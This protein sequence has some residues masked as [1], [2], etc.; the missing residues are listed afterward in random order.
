MSFFSSTKD[1]PQ[2]KQKPLGLDE[3]RIATNEQARPVPY[4]CGIARLAVTF[5]SEAF[6]VK[7]KK[8]KM[9]VGKKQETVGYNYIASFAALIA[10]GPLDRLDAIWMDDE[11]V[12]EGPLARSGDFADIT[13]EDRG[14]VR[15][16][17]GTETQVQDP[18]LATSGT[19]HPAYRGQAYLVFDQ[20]FFGRDR[21]NAP[22]IE[23][24]VARWPNAP[25]LLTPNSI[26][27]DVNPVIPLWDLWTNP[28]YGLG[29]PESRLDMDA[30]AAVG[31]QL[32]AEGIGVSPVI[33]RAFNFRQFLVELCECFDAYP[34]YDS[35]GRLGLA[36]VRESAAAPVTVEPADLVDAPTL[37]PQGWPGTFN[38]TF[39][40]FTNRDKRFQEDSVAYRDRGNFQITQAVLS[41]TLSRLWITRQGVAQ[42]IANAAGRVAAQ[43]MLAGSMQVRKSKASALSVGG[44]FSLSFPQS[45]VESVLCRVE[46]LTLPAPG[47]AAATV[48]FREDTGFFNSDHYAA[49]ADDVPAENVFEVQALGYE[50]LIEAPWGLK[51]T[52]TPQ[53]VF[54]AARG[55]LVSNGF[56][57]WKQ[58]SDLS[59]RDV[60]AFDNFAQRGHVVAEYPAGTLLIDDYLGIEIQFDSLDNDLDEIT[61]LEAQQNRLLV[62]VGGEILSG[63]GAQLIAAGRYR[64][65]AIRARFDTKRQT[66]PAAT[67]VWVA[68][69]D[70]LAMR[71]D[72]M[73][74]PDKAFKLQPFL[75]QSEFDL[76]LVDPQE[77]TLQKRAYRPLVP[78]NL[79]VAGDGYNPT[80]ATGADIVADWDRAANRSSEDPVS[81]VLNSDIDQT[82]LEVLTT[83]DVLQGTFEFSGGT[84]PR[85]ITNAQLVATL[86]SETDF[87]LRAWF[88][89]SGYRSLSFDEVTVRKV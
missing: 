46:R 28:R 38:E 81:K 21:T 16:Y 52:S 70:D 8:I 49:G 62:F 5:I 30:L 79:R 25:W 66:H 33:T 74:P 31:E 51:E 58:R 55:D 22:N 82:V 77:I 29:L 50:K 73:S 43:P 86:G 32:N 2:P 84:G 40:R 59:Y 48:Q 13:I 69:R 11:L 87:K 88:V 75:L 35:Q 1:L 27:D 78:L 76:A 54:L 34:T 47:Q 61:F 15:L 23:V 85:T 4:F 19:V 7:S 67:E 80:Y 56:N 44:L 14:N 36:L 60:G 17:W 63:W 24:L 64:L 39:V 20:L 18:L 10:H 26:E 53:I 72:D 89:R 83:G 41:Q 3:R 6:G 9:R 71:S 68:L 57:L 12:W 45:G 37:N 65:W 42:K